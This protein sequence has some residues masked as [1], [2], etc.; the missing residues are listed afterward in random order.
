MWKDIRFAEDSLN[1]TKR[2]Q[3]VC[4][5]IFIMKNESTKEERICI[6]L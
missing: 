5:E 6:I 4:D 1:L 3:R 2:R